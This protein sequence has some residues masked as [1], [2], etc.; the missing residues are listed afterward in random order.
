[1]IVSIASFA[2]ACKRAFFLNKKNFK[3]ILTCEHAKPQIPF[4]IKK[5]LFIPKNIL[6]S[7]RG[8]DKGAL[9]L[10]QF[11]QRI[12]FVKGFYFPIS[13]LAIDANRRL[14]SK[15]SFSIFSKEL[16][17]VDKKTLQ[18]QYKKYRSQVDSCIAR[19]KNSGPLYIFSVHSF[20]GTLNGKRRNTDLGLLFRPQN[21]K[22]FELAKLIKIELNKEWPTLK[23]HFNLPYRGHT[24][25]FL[26][27]ILDKHGRHKNVNGVF[28]EMNQRTFNNSKK[29]QK[30]SYCLLKALKAVA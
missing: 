22:E 7:H 13:R 21:K 9:F 20:T 30:L 6:N 4:G 8:Y 1:M 2:I 15:N 14:D 18:L 24:D 26:N 11:M 27:D 19:Q 5:K 28:I 10:V 25:C 29:I 3:I 17:A 23:V 12:S 16:S